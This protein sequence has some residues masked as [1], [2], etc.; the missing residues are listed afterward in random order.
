MQ[1]DI[2]TINRD[3]WESEYH[4]S[5][6]HNNGNNVNEKK[7]TY[8]LFV[9]N[10]ITYIQ[11]NAEAEKVNLAHLKNL[12]ELEICYY[13]DGG[14]GRCVCEF[15]FIDRKKTLRPFLILNNNMKA[16]H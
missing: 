11:R 15:A 2:L 12:D 9:K 1:K 6:I 5:F 10:L 7:K 14:G 8:L 3:D 4:D 16:L 13:G